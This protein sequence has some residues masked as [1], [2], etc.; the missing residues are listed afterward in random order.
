[1]ASGVF[2]CTESSARANSSGYTPC[3]NSEPD[4]LSPLRRYWGYDAFRPLQERI[5]RSLLGR[6]RRLRRDANR[7]RQIAVLSIARRDAAG[8]NRHRGFAADRADAGSGGATRAN[9]NPGGAAEQFADAAAQQ[10][11]VMRKARAGA[12][13]ACCIFRRSAW[14]APTRSNG[15]GGMPISFFAIDEAHCISEWGHEFRPDYRQL[16]RLRVHFPDLPDRRVHRQRHAARAARHHSPAQACA[17]RTNT[18]PAFTG[19]ICATS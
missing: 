8:A 3:V 12:N 11:Q 16:S 18:S 4:L 6:P 15:C 10:S 19:P 5:V 9:G 14:R 17:I 13:T 1:M 2:V 7:R